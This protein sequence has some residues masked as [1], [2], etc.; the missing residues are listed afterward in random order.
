MHLGAGGG[1]VDPVRLGDLF[2]GQSHLGQGL[3]DSAGMASGFIDGE[4]PGDQFGT[5]VPGAPYPFVVYAP[6]E[7][8]AN[9]QDSGRVYV[10]LGGF[11][12]GS[13]PSDATFSF[14]GAAADERLGAAADD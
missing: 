8:T 10:L 14:V 6:G 4:A 11:A 5:L 13:T 9:G 2:V 7:D 1:R 3:S 12:A